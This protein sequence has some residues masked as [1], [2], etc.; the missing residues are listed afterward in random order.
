ME[1]DLYVHVELG[2]D[3]KY[4]VKGKGTFIFLLELGGSL[5]A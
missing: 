3:S 5:H 1:R 4:V 2:D